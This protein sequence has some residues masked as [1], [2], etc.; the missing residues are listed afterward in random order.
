MTLDGATVPGRRWQG[1][2]S[3]STRLGRLRAPSLS[4]SLSC[5]FLVLSAARQLCLTKRSPA[6]QRKKRRT[7]PSEARQCPLFRGAAAETKLRV[8]GVPVPTRAVPQ[9]TT[10]AGGASTDNLPGENLTAGQ[11]GQ[12]YTEA[13]RL[14][15]SQQT[16]PRRPHTSTVASGH[17]PHPAQHLS[18]NAICYSGS[19]CPRKQTLTSSCHHRPPGVLGGIWSPTATTLTLLGSALRGWLAPLPISRT[20][21]GLPKP[22]GVGQAHSS[23]QPEEVQTRTSTSRPSGQ[24]T[25]RPPHLTGHV[26][27]K[28]QLLRNR[29]CTS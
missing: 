19:P 18:Q 14:S 2:S 28:T 25:S 20:S 24:R 13:Q 15:C 12:K 1:V 9:A 10:M 29:A 7:G 22:P 26:H 23:L 6:S 4:A 3:G 11:A 8:P 16:R 27:F 21:R 5:L 17:R